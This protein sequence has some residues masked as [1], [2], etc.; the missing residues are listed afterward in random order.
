MGT[1]SE[2]IELFAELDGAKTEGFDTTA[3][4]V[5]DEAGDVW[6]GAKCYAIACTE[7]A[8]RA[9]AGWK[10]NVRADMSIFVLVILRLYLFSSL[11]FNVD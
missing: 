2:I 6:Y 10:Q 8:A 9:M 3:M 7:Q 5:A 1:A 11:K 4:A